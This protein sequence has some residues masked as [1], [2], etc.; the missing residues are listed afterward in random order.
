[1]FLNYQKYSKHHVKIVLVRITITVETQPH[2]HY[3]PGDNLVSWQMMIM[4]IVLIVV[5]HALTTTDCVHGVLIDHI[6]LILLPHQVWWNLLWRGQDAL[7]PTTV[8]V[9]ITYCPTRTCYK[10]KDSHLDMFL[11]LDIKVFNM[12]IAVSHNHEGSQ[13]LA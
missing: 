8:L 2:G 6:R 7:S 10:V 9:L 11:R 1:M 5:S 13:A 3:T 12:A 4:T